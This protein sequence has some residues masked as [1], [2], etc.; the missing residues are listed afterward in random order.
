M[1]KILYLV[2]ILM[3]GIYMT[4]CATPGED[5]HVHGDTSVKTYPRGYV[6]PLT[7]INFEKVVQENRGLKVLEENATTVNDYYRGAVQEKAE[8]ESFLREGKWEEAETH[9]DKS[10]RFI[11]TVL[12]Y[13]PEDNA[14][15]N[16]YGDQVVIFLPNL[17]SADNY[18]KLITIYRKMGRDDK[19]AEAA[20][21]GKDYLSLSLKH[22]KTEWAI[23]LQ[24]QLG[25]K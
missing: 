22:V 1:K 14:S 7:E 4:R 6:Y 3:S 25:E 8:G 21:Y 15:W 19:V 18:L 13:F 5:T 20:K 9:L 2:M 17:L 12:R 16:I 10:N 11:R 23:D 24:K